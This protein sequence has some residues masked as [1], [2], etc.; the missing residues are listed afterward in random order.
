[1][2]WDSWIGGWVSSSVVWVV[3]RPE[4]LSELKVHEEDPNLDSGLE[5]ELFLL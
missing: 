3:E 4:L 2:A 1:M 5:P